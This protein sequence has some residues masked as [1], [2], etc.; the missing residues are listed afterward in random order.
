AVELSALLDEATVRA[1]RSYFA[2]AAE[3]KER[4]E[5]VPTLIQ[6]EE[7][8]IAEVVGL[9]AVKYADLSQ[10]RTSDYVFN[11]DKML[12]MDGN[13]ATYMQYAYARI[14]SIFRKGGVEDSALRQQAPVALLQEPQERALALDLLRFADALEAAAAEYKPNLITGYLWDLAKSYSGFYQNCLVLNAGSDELRR[15]RLMLCDLTGRTIRQGLD[16]LGIGTVERM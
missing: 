10:N 7:Q 6:T 12:A 1:G 9:G 5:D 4:G 11:W 16:L 13:T 8:S 14:R 15:S 2:S 3:R